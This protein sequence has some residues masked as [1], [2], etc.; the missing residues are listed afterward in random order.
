LPRPDH[1]NQEAKKAQRRVTVER[2][3]DVCLDGVRI[4]TR[5]VAVML[6]YGGGE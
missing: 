4:S 6:R 2:A 1:L 5:E 3:E